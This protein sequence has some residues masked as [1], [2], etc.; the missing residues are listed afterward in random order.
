[1][2]DLDVWEFE[3]DRLVLYRR[4]DRQ[5]V[6]CTVASVQTV[7]LPDRLPRRPNGGPDSRTAPE[8]ENDDQDFIPGFDPSMFVPS[9]DPSE[10]VGEEHE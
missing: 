7:D 6:I 1:M 10:L 5:I 2:S 8:P 3:N 9:G 4:A